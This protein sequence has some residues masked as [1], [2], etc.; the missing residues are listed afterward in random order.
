MA[1]TSLSSS[2]WPSASSRSRCDARSVE[3]ETHA[4][5]TARHKARVMNGS[6]D[7]GGYG[8]VSGHFFSPRCE[9]I[10]LA[11]HN[12]WMRGSLRGLNLGQR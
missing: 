8:A 5:T 1:S 7:K 4:E 2:P 10:S 6:F 11:R 12:R 3:P 9:A